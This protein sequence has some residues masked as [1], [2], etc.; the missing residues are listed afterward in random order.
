MT[1]IIAGEFGGR[2]LSVPPR[3]TRPTT[4]RVREAL[5]SRLDHSD[6]LRDAVA[7]DLYAGSG[8]LGFEALSRGAASVTLV[9][10]A[11]SA[12]RVLQGNVRTLSVGTRARVVKEKAGSFVSRTAGSYDLVMIDPPYDLPPKEVEAVLSALPALLAPD[13][14]VVLES[15]TR[16]E[17][18]TWPAQ[19]EIVAQKD[20]GETRLTYAALAEARSGDEADPGEHSEPDTAAGA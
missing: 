13:A 20:Y 4:D 18:A 11:A 14:T 5:F 8:A 17:A 3:G 2:R 16:A 12:A 19:L 10:S 7:L 1:R 15:S 9:E 6:V